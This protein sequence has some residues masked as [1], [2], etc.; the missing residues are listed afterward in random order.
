MTTLG[1]DRIVDR[2]PASLRDDALVFEK[3][4]VELARMTDVLLRRHGKSIVDQQFALERLANVSIAHQFSQLAK[5]RMNRNI[6]AMLR[7]EDEEAKVLA[8]YIFD[9]QSYP[10]DTLNA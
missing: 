10:W 4:T 8:Q 9:T 6:R 2:V 1:R 7:N 5:R 3:Y